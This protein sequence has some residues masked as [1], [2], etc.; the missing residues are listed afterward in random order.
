MGDRL[1][2]LGAVGIPFAPAPTLTSDVAFCL[3]FQMGSAPQRPLEAPFPPF[4]L[5]QPLDV[6]LQQQQGVSSSTQQ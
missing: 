3:L 1:G 5:A 6:W 4:G 2:T